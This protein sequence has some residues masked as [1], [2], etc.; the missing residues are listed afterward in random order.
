V[1]HVAYVVNDTGIP[2]AWKDADENASRYFPTPGETYT[3]PLGI[4]TVYVWARDDYCE[5]GSTN[6]AIIMI[7]G[8]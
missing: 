3:A 6:T 4:T 2:G 8:E 5:Y 1:T 7:R